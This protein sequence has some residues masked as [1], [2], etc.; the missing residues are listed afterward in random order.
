LL[1]AVLLGLYKF[2]QFAADLLLDW[3]TK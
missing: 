3:P 2:Y 1:Q